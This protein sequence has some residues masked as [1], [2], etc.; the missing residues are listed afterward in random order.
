[1]EKIEDCSDGFVI[2]GEGG[3][4]IKVILSWFGIFS[5]LGLG[6]VVLSFFCF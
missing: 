3:D 5:F 1:M 4:G 2:K 6:K